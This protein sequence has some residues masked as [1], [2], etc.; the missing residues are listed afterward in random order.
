MTDNVTVLI[1]AGSIGLAI[2]R[3]VSAGN[4]VFVADRNEKAVSA[5]ERTLLDAGFDAR[6]AY[7]DLADRQ[8][9]RS[10]ARQAFEI[11]SVTRVIQAAGVSPSQASVETILR[12]DMYGTAA[13]LEEFGRAVTPGGS[14]LV[15]ASQSGHRLPALSPEEDQLLATTPVEEL[16]DLPFI[17]PE[18]ISSTLHAYQ[19]AKRANTLRVAYEAVRWGEVGARINAISPGIVITPLARDELSGSHGAEYRTMLDKAPVGRAGTPDEIAS[20]AAFLMGPEGAFITGTDVLMDGGATAAWHYG[21]IVPG[22]Q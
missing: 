1:G 7:V 11:G 21:S 9:V 3:R 16:L 8:T 12:V 14:G 20:M 5:V 6:A 22:L 17:R 18:N 4:T 15:I 13:V 19:L 2:A 10:L